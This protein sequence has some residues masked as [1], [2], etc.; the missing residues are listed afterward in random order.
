[1]KKY[2][3]IL[4]ACLG[5]LSLPAQTLF[6][7]GD[8][9][10]DAKEFLRAY[11]KNNT[12]KVTD[13]AKS[14]NEYLNLYI[15]SRLKIH[16]AYI[17]KYDTIALLRDDVNNLRAQIIENYMNDPKMTEKLYNEA[18]RRSLRDIH[19]AHIFIA[20][21]NAAGIIDTTGARTKSD[22]ILR[23]LQ[24]EDFLKIAAQFSDD[25]SAKT[26]KG[27]MG[28]VT[29]FTLPYEFENIIY[30]TPA[31]KYSAP[32]RSK[33]GYH[34]FKNLGERKAVGKIKAQQIL[35]AI[36]PGTDEAAKKQ[37]AK[38][39]DSL[40]KRIIAGD[41]FE[42]L[43]RTFS[44]DYISAASGGTMP[45]ISVGQFAPQ[46]EAVLW[47]LSKD[48]AVSKPFLTSHGY[49]IVK[50]IA[51]KPVIADPENNA[52]KLELQQKITTDGRWKAARDFIYDLVKKNPGLKRN[53][54]APAVL[55]A[56]SDSLLQYQPIGIGKE[57]TRET[58]LF[59]IGNT[60][61]TAGDWVNYA[62]AFR[63]KPD[64]SGAKPYELVM[65]E[66][67]NQ[68]LFNYYRDH[69]EDYNEEFKMQMQEFRDGNLFFEIMQREIWNKA[70]NDS[71]SLAALYEKNKSGYTWKESADVIAFFCVDMNT[72]QSVYEEMKKN[73][74]DWRNI[75]A[76]QT[77]KLAADSSR[78]EW[79][80]IPGLNKKIPKSG[81]FTAPALNELDK[82]ASF[83]YIVKVYAQPSQRS[84]NEARG[85][86][87][88]D[89]QNLLEE[90]WIESLKKK[91][92]VVI[93][94]KVLAEIA[95]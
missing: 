23:R 32:Y 65:E 20:Y 70:Q 27:D 25:T 17:R 33:L 85:M 90:Q 28:W 91:Y 35:L 3:L 75:A 69:L 83:A 77:E 78:Y 16:E 64:G 92:P 55:W 18:F 40:Y 10:V 9:A 6:T 67:I 13:K 22:D 1:M 86:V 12:Q 45:E 56:F 34:I 30:A 8:V 19:T 76:L 43:A 88:S 15:N 2:L 74:A 31:G 36:P 57:I 41:D 37:L 80:Q 68:S 14:M 71:V 53:A 89:Y 46:F 42:T 95:K 82:T 5:M 81:Q 21:R 79:E 66:F 44:N 72:A 49:H 50:R 48:G 54:Y 7:Y 4:I 24:K 58:M 84:F 87:I 11:N 51:V 60:A 59:T 47:G 63:F 94:Q 39:A 61:Y 62:Q 52:N 73:P 38:K 93:D 26:N 29:V